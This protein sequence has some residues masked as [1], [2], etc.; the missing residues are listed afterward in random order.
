MKNPYMKPALCIGGAFLVATAALGF[1]G[2]A[3]AKEPA[4]E[5]RLIGYCGGRIMAAMEESAFP[6]GCAWIEPIRYVEDGGPAWQE[7]HGR[8]VQL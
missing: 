6:S 1:S 7:E 3:P 2:L 5:A 8:K 4:V